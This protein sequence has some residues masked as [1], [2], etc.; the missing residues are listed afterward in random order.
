MWARQTAAM[1]VVS[2]L[3]DMRRDFPFQLINY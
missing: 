2:R 3:D 1:A